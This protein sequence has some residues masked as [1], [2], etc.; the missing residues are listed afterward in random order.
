MRRFFVLFSL[1]VVGLFSAVADLPSLSL[2]ATEIHLFAGETVRIQA[3]ATAGATSP[4]LSVD[5]AFA[6]SFSA[7][8]SGTTAT[9]ELAWVAQ[10]PGEYALDITAEHEG[11]VVFRTV[12]VRVD[13]PAPEVTATAYS[14]TALH[15]RAEPVPGATEYRIDLETS[16]GELW[17]YR[18]R[19]FPVLLPN[20]A[21]GG[22]YTARVMALNGSRMSAESE[23]SVRTLTEAKPSVFFVQ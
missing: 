10:Y 5:D 4:T 23:L 19:T 7:Q 15:F 17:R 2:S 6:T 21:P 9:G 13:L 11:E 20:L 1:Y 8:Y 16:A 22:R 3:V 12:R 18:L 14:T